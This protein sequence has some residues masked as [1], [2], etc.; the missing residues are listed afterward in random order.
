IITGGKGNDTLSGGPGDDTYIYNR[1]DGNDT[2]IEGGG[3]NFSAIDTLVLHGINPG[4]VSVVRNGND[5]TLI[6][7]ASAP[8]A[9]DGGSVLLK[10][11]LND[12]FSQGVEQITF[13]D[14]TVWT[15]ATLRLRLL[16]QAET[17]GNDTVVG[18]NTDDVITG[19]RGDDTLSGGP[20]D[21]TYI[22]NRGDGNDTIIEGGGGNFSAID[23][24]V[25]HGINPGDVSVVRNG[26]DATLTF[27]ESA[28]GAGDGGSVL[29]KDEL[30]DSFYQG[31]EQ[32]TFDDGTVWTQATL[33]LRLLAQAETSGNDTII[34]YNTN[35]VITG[36]LGD[37]TLEGGA[38]DD[39]YIYN[40]GD[41]NDTI[42]EDPAGNFSTFDTLVLQDI[43]PGDVSVVRNGNDVTLMIAA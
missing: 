18:Y 9:G 32:I 2:I 34:G 36:G 4:D 24:L 25:L 11:E 38:G 23:T 6:F 39:T 30:N 26:N 16:A 41:G 14:G 8:G 31:V 20:G 3:G 17:S 10:D 43:N 29:L 33:R 28:P 22:Y 40:R 1:G 12:F 15:Q 21:D 13:D 35:D 7:A 37:D 19:G 27:A 5:A 42:I